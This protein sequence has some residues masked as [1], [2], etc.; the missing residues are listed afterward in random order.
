VRRPEPCTAGGIIDRYAGTASGLAIQENVLYNVQSVS[1]ILDTLIFPT[2][3]F[4]A[5]LLVIDINRATFIV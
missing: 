1:Y 4:G 3:Y 2:I 5:V